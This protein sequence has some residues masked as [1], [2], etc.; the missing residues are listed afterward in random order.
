MMYQSLFLNMVKKKTLPPSVADDPVRREG[1]IE[2][3]R[4]LDEN[5]EV[6]D[7]FEAFQ[8]AL[9]QA[10]NKPVTG[11]LMDT[12]TAR[13]YQNARKQGA[14]SGIMPRITG[15]DAPPPPEP[16][17]ED[18]LREITDVGPVRDGR[19]PKPKI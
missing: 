13:D 5:G 4:L 3:Q 1:Y 6:R 14:L 17:L 19:T 18:K 10:L 8:R 11:P 9:N 2:G 7:T 16:S 15:K 12:E